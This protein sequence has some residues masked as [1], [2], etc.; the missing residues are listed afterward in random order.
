MAAFWAGVLSGRGKHSR[1]ATPG[2]QEALEVS[3]EANH[4]AT[5]LVFVRGFFVFFFQYFI[6]HFALN[7]HVYQLILNLK[8][9]M[10]AIFVP[11]A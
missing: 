6:F 7:T 8:S 3:R 10:C 4:N 2:H 5:L 1:A 9:K 11:F